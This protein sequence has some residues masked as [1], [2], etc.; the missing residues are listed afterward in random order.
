MVIFLASGANFRAI[1]VSMYCRRFVYLG[2]AC[3]DRFIIRLHRR[4]SGHLCENL[5]FDPDCTGATHSIDT[6]E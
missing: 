2:N 5:A 6:E 3:P 1:F 4:E